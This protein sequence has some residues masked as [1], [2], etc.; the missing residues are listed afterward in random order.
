[1]IEGAAER[2]CWLE[3]NA[4]PQRLDLDDVRVRAARDAGVRISIA[5]DAHAP[6]QLDY[7]RYG[8]AQARR[9][10]IERGD[11]VNA[12]SLSDLREAIRH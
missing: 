3:L 9:G 1:V 7:M 4:Q 12:L 5:S 11:V 2:G 6:E 10:W 8:V